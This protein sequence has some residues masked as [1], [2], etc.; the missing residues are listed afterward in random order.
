MG[1]RWVSLV[2]SRPSRLFWAMVKY[3]ILRAMESHRLICMCASMLSH[4]QLFVT[5]VTAVHQ[6]PLSMRFSRQEYWIGLPFPPPGDLPDP[7][8]EPISPVS[9]ALA[10]WFFTTKAPVKPLLSD[11]DSHKVTNTKWD[12]EDKS[13]KMSKCFVSKGP[14][15]PIERILELNWTSLCINGN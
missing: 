4:V 13:S 3:S 14:A 9:P 2:E 10:G 6:A 8:I 12:W 1:G 15:I 5:S 7:G 11:L